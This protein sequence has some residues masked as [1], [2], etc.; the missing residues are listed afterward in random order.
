MC[1]RVILFV[2]ASGLGE[3][4]KLQSYTV[5]E[6]VK[7]RLEQFVEESKTLCF[8][9]PDTFCFYPL[10]FLTKGYSKSM[11]TKLNQWHQ[12]RGS[13]PYLSLLCVWLL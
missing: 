5:H 7:T 3:L 12:N 9:F 13:P 2:F 6:F 1:R 4:L 8:F 11:A 10:S